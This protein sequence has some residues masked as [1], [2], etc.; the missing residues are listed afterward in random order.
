M[1]EPAIAAELLDR[2]ARLLVTH[3]LGGVTGED[4]V[5]IKGERIGTFVGS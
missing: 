2:W 4:R 1:H 3:S 5:M